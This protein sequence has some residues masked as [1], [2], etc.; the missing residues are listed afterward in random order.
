MLECYYAA[1]NV[2]APRAYCFAVCSREA[3]RGE[4]SFSDSGTGSRWGAVGASSGKYWRQCSFNRRNVLSV[5]NNATSVVAGEH[6]RRVAGTNSSVAVDEPR[7]YAPFQIRVAQECHAAP[8]HCRQRTGERGHAVL[9]QVSAFERR[10]RF[11]PNQVVSPPVTVQR[12]PSAR[13][14]RYVVRRAAVSPVFCVLRR[15]RNV[16]NASSSLNGRDH[17]EVPARRYGVQPCLRGS[18]TG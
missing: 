18:A 7:E 16:M 2:P 17:R 10:R 6:A 9:L 3:A 14:S 15:R 1:V 4:G 5:R 13:W 12:T 11:A 8:K